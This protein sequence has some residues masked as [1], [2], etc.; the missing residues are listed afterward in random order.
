MSVTGDANQLAALQQ[1][2]SK[3]NYAELI[4]EGS[5]KGGVSEKLSILP[6]SIK[7]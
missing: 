3:T 7:T 1:Q 2:M 4:D 5:N 6:M